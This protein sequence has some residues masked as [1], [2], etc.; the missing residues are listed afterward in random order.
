ADAAARFRALGGDP[1]AVR[2]LAVDADDECLDRICRAWPAAAGLEIRNYHHRVTTLAPLSRLTAIKKLV[3]DDGA[4]STLAPLAKLKSLTSLS[5]GSACSRDV[6]VLTALPALREL[7]ITGPHANLDFL[8]PLTK[9]ER[10]SLGWMDAADLA[11]L[12]AL[13]ALTSLSLKC[14][15]PVASQLP[16]L[17]ALEEL[18]IDGCRIPGPDLAF[19]TPLARLK[20]LTLNDLT[21]TATPIVSLAP[22][23][24]LTNLEEL[25][26]SKCDLASSDLAFLRPLT[27]LRRLTLTDLPKCQ[28]SV[29]DADVLG[30]LTELRLSE[31]VAPDALDVR[32]QTQD[33]RAKVF[34]IGIDEAALAAICRAWPRLDGLALCRDMNSFPFGDS[35]A[36]PAPPLTAATL[37][38]LTNLTRL[39]IDGGDLARDGLGFL[40]PLGKL[41]ALTLT[42][43]PLP[44]LA[45]L[46]AR[47]EL[48]AIEELTIDDCGAPCRYL[49]P[50]ATL[51][52]LR[53]LALEK[54]PGGLPPLDAPGSLSRLERLRLTAAAPKK[55]APAPGIDMETVD[56]R[57][58]IRACAIDDAALAAACRVWPGAASVQIKQSPAVTSLAP[59]QG[60][61]ALKELTIDGCA[62]PAPGLAFLAPFKK[63]S[64]LNCPVTVS[65]LPPAATKTLRQ[66]TQLNLTI[67]AP[68]SAPKGDAASPRPT[69][70][71]DWFYDIDD[72]GNVIV[73]D[74]PAGGD[75][76]DDDT[77]GT[78]LAIAA[79]HLDDAALRA[80]CQIWPRAAG[81]TIADSPALSTL[82][83]LAAMKGLIR[84]KIE[85]SALAP[86][87]LAVLGRLGSL[88]RLAIADPVGSGWESGAA[89]ELKNQGGK[90]T[91]AAKRLGEAALGA[92]CQAWPGAAAL[93]L[94]QC[95]DVKALAPLAR[96]T[97][98][99]ELEIKGI[100]GKEY[101]QPTIRL[102]TGDGLTVKISAGALGDAVVNA[103]CQTWP[104]ATAIAFDDGVA[105]TTLAPLAAMQSL[106]SLTLSGLKPPA[107]LGLAPLA[108]L[109]ALEEL[110]IAGKDFAPTDL[111]FLKPLARLR[112]LKLRKLELATLAPLGAMT[113]LQELTIDHCPAPAPLALT[114][115][116]A[117]TALE[118]LTLNGGQF[119]PTDLAFLKPLTRL[120]RLNLDGINLTAGLAPLARLPSLEALS[121]MWL[122]APAPLAPAPLRALT[123]LKELTIGYSDVAPLDF[124]LLR[125]LAQLKRLD[126]DKTTDGQPSASDAEVLKRL[127]DLRLTGKTRDG[128]LAL[129]NMETRE[130]RNGRRRTIEAIGID[131]AALAALCEAGATVRELSLHGCPN[132][133]ALAPAM[134][135]GAV[136]ELKIAKH[137]ANSHGW[138]KHVSPR[139][140]ITDENGFIKVDAPEATRE[141]MADLCRLCPRAAV[142]A[143]TNCRDVAALA[144]FA[145]MTNLR[146]LTLIGRGPAD[147]RAEIR[148]DGASGRPIIHA[149]RIDDA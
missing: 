36:P 93:T 84:L 132:L 9:L 68:E 113:G 114:P 64:R 76:D 88:Q 34:A 118:S 149:T 97:G 39:A 25:E 145:A 66:F 75:G 147:R 11:P 80:I 117:L 73:D 87:D 89:I 137:G 102:Q 44:P 71:V 82:A 77:T 81:L 65:G 112:R 26:I 125:P 100:P 40:Q 101:W 91:I 38:P 78:P 28:L 55:G 86:A 10:L 32:L 94:D 37:A 126:L 127:D 106:T 17:P 42:R 141:E 24:G 138:S 120:R 109:A 135:K 70:G 2:I 96:L 72:D 92:L 14:V 136:W 59:L 3:I 4:F 95:P 31:F 62:A 124:S 20:R 110:T 111:A 41:R 21:L 6:A 33:G 29:N 90:V 139:I 104:Q 43:T 30:R 1:A 140:R 63:L 61:T 22:V 130:S 49:A 52:E 50:F 18:T 146:R 116:S 74:A 35:P 53:R 119:A 19:L 107:P 121:L 57:T 58:R 13:P 148:V 123:G 45:A 69:I 83:P 23:S 79:A 142:M 5:L 85:N 122:H 134:A 98:A 67:A 60:L 129:L 15:T 103:V 108:S 47:K 143:F 131:A 46:V 56:G 16:S 8:K 51:G 54:L 12:A 128:R 27:R 48:A 133:A 99:K 7:E 105:V 144:P 115:L